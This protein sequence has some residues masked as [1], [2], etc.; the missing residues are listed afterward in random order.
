M[1]FFGSFS[2]STFGEVSCPTE[3]LSIQPSIDITGPVLAC[4]GDVNAFML[5]A[6]GGGGVDGGETDDNDMDVF[7]HSS[8]PKSAASCVELFTLIIKSFNISED[9]E[10]VLLLVRAKNSSRVLFDF[11]F[12]L[13]ESVEWAMSIQPSSSSASGVENLE[14]E[15]ETDNDA[16]ADADPEAEDKNA[17][18]RCSPLPSSDTL[19]RGV[20]SSDGGKSSSN[21]L[22][23]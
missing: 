19:L 4:V 16:D 13:D 8:P 5:L 21:G 18:R 15:A 11:S 23:L 6:A 20:I 7:V 1:S 9:I 17:D 2:F 12:G 3:G 22:G 10:S 14:F